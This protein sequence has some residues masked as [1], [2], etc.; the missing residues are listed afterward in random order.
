MVDHQAPAFPTVVVARAAPG[1]VPHFPDA[2]VLPDGRVLCTYRE[3][4]GHVRADGRIMLAE[5]ADGGQTWSEPRVAVDGVH[6]DR[7]PKLAVLADG[8]VLLSYFVLEWH[9][10]RPP[11]DV[12]GTFVTRSKD[13]GRTWS[14]PLRVGAPADGPDDGGLRWA[15]S[16]GAAVE[17][18]GGEL[19]LPLYG[20]DHAVSA[21][22]DRALVVRSRDG[23][24]TWD[25]DS[26]TSLATGDT[27]H[28]QEPTLTVLPGGE[29]VALIRTSVEHAYLARSRDG[30]RSWS[31]PAETDLPASSHHA[32]PLAE[33]GVLVAYGDIS[34]RFS[35]MRTTVAR[36][37]THPEAAWTGQ[38][39]HI[40]DSGHRDQANPSTVEVGPGRYL[41]IGFDV[42]AATVVGVFTQRSD[43]G[44]G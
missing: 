8:T 12:W 34:G 6:D 21:E 1:T 24:V 39:L 28:F 20:R 31:E 27:F 38:D 40:Y 23:G 4:T 36:I 3:S 22:W 15:V 35:E 13:G 5:S 18:P 11:Y 7:D 9:E 41:T 19:L 16:H 33:G 26:A 29:V 30:G 2:V 37:V 25:P 43:Y 10:G 17:L 42:P 32:L 44:E 14:E